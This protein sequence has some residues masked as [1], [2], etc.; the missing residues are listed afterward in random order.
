MTIRIKDPDQARKAA[1]GNQRKAPPGVY[2]MEIIRVKEKRGRFLMMLEVAVGPE[3][4]S[5]CFDSYD[6][7]HPVGGGILIRRLEA[8]GV[9][10]D[11]DGAF[12]EADVEGCFAEVE[13][14]ENNGYVNV[15][16]MKP[17]SADDAARIVATR[18]A[19]E[20]APAEEATAID[21]ADDVPF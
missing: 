9:T 17:I 2:V 10:I 12:D 7:S 11:A 19:A 13:L 20:E 1:G 21:P 4:G 16:T 8:L 14:I 15:K 5:V 18:K 3:Q 6:L